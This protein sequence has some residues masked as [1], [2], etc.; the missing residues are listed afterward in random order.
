MNEIEAKQLVINAFPEYNLNDL[1]CHGGIEKELAKNIEYF[2]R[3]Q[4]E[5]IL[6]SKTDLAFQDG[7][8]HISWNTG[9]SI[10]FKAIENNF[11]R[12]ASWRTPETWDDKVTVEYAAP[13]GM[14]FRLIKEIPHV[15]SN[16]N[17]HYHIQIID[18][19]DLTPI[20]TH[21][22]VILGIS[23]DGTAYIVSQRTGTLGD[24]EKFIETHLTTDSFF[25]IMER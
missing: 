5:V 2:T 16:G 4:W 12:L 13:N 15:F 22:A 1:D 20:C 25:K 21:T 7:I 6:S 17:Y 14:Y 10:I 19:K 9:R 8:A 24:C 3:E 18:E 23:A 11:K